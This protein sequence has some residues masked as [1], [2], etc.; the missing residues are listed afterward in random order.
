MIQDHIEQIEEKVQKTAGLS[1]ETKSELLNLLSELKVEVSNLSKTNQEDARSVAHFVAAS[2]HEATRMERK[3]EQAGAAL[4][5]LTASV[6]GLEGS[7]PELTALVNRIA[8][9]LSN[10]GI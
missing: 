6:E 7:H 3:P 5:G 10:M 8:V 9:T 4:R 2:A 1:S